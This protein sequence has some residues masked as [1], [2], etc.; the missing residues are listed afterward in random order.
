MDILNQII[1]TEED[2]KKLIEMLDK[3]NKKWLS[4][5]D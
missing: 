4:K 2:Q 3:K 5:L 1:E